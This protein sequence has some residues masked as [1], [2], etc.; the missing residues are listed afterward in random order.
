MTSKA[1]MYIFSRHYIFH[2]KVQ[3]LC[4][5]KWQMLGKG[6][7]YPR[8]TNLEFLTVEPKNP[9]ASISDIK[10]H[11]QLFQKMGAL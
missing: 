3:N 7:K 10:C 11:F 4:W 8:V 2:S 1:K 6:T 9:D 5:L